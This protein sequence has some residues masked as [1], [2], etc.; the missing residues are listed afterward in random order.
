[1]Y[2]E[3]E[4]NRRFLMK[5]ILTKTWDT[6]KTSKSLNSTLQELHDGSYTITIEKTLQTRSIGQNRLYW[7]A[8]LWQIVHAFR[9]KGIYT[10][11]QSLHEEFKA[12]YLFYYKK[13][14]F[15]GK[16]IK[17]IK[18]TTKLTTK[19]FSKLM[20]KVTEWLIAH[21]MPAPDLTSLSDADLLYWE[22]YL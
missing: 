3:Y 9:E 21:D 13:S 19:D 16:N 12:R 11:K 18:S 15:T 4:F 20:E 14:V 22:N 1:M 8:F 5:I 10:D 17:H 6:I 2:W 7:G